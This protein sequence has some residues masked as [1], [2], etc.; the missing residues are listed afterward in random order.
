M[1][2]TI[3]KMPD[4][5]NKVPDTT[6][7]MPDNAQEQQIYRIEYYLIRSNSK[8]LLLIYFRCCFQDG[9]VIPHLHTE[10]V[11]SVYFCH[12]G[13]YNKDR[14]GKTRTRKNEHQWTQQQRRSG[15]KR[16]ARRS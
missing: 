13:N 10:A 6:D 14:S 8:G 2:D 9:E 15:L 3:G 1:P 16:R 7:K 5:A 12:Y 4:Y 11:L